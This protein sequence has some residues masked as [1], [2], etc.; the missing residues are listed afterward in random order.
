[1][2]IYDNIHGYIEISNLAEKIINTVYFQRLRNIS[3][4]GSLE[5]VWPTANHTRFSHSVGTYHLAKLFIT[6]LKNRQ[7]ELMISDKL[8]EL[9]SLAGL[10]HDLGHLMFSHLF[11]DMFLKKLDNYD[12][13]GDLV[14]HENRSIFLLKHIIK[15]NKINIDEKELLVIGDLINPKKNSYE[16]WDKR[17]K[18]GKWIFEI[19]SNPVNNIDVDKFDYI[20][21][22][23]NAIGLKLNFDYSRLIKQARVIND[24]ICYP[25]QVQNDIYHMFLI[26]Y[27][28]H[29]EIYNH[30]IV[31]AVDIL[32][33]EALFR[34]EE[35]EKISTHLNDP[36]KLL[37]LTDKYLYFINCDKIKS[38]LKRIDTR[39]FP[40]L[41]YENISLKNISI[42]HKK[43]VNLPFSNYF[44]FIKFKAG[45]ISGSGN[46]PLKN[47]VF[48]NSN[49]G[50][51]INSDI[52]TSF[53][54][55]IN[56]NHQENFLRI[57]SLKK[58]NKDDIH[59]IKMKVKELIDNKVNYLSWYNVL[60][61]LSSIYFIK[62]IFN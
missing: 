60:I 16:L 10:C 21:R 43:L 30:K 48:Y 44:K 19:I 55:L 7:P 24:N 39:D 53:S 46:N 50:N 26:R 45:Y 42:D 12:Q 38:I 59:E 58:I 3:Q 32:L 22:D 18:V 4:T 31:K 2:Y 57:Y 27:R 35:K 15:S 5:R 13:L 51:I 61:I 8:I 6:S 34:L 28:L 14:E 23:N 62:K 49:T 41:I 29:R 52:G 37:K 40:S 33:T 11:D 9:V 25:S 36:D 1:V 20:H 54:K 56:H 17:F 47:I